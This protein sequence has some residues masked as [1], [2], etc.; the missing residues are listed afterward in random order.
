VAFEG[1]QAAR[2][3]CCSQHD[4]F[5]PVQNAKLEEC[6]DRGPTDQA[7][8]CL[9]WQPA[10]SMSFPSNSPELLALIVRPEARSRAVKRP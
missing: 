7:L 4:E 10:C 2:E 3:V 9:T 5:E 6:V 8:L 1:R